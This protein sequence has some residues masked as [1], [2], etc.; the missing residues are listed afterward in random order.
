LED[1]LDIKDMMARVR[2]K[3]EELDSLEQRR[4]NLNVVQPIGAVPT[5]EMEDLE[6]RIRSQHAQ[7][8]QSQEQVFLRYVAASFWNDYS[9]F[10]TS[11]DSALNGQDPGSKFVTVLPYNYR[12]ACEGILHGYEPR[13]DAIQKRV[14]DLLTGGIDAFAPGLKPYQI[15]AYR[16]KDDPRRWTPWQPDDSK[17]QPPQFD[18]KG[19]ADS[20]KEGRVR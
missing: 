19:A 12:A 5:P 10:T 4:R 14:I 18:L 8:M 20:R 1:A 11:L 16:S 9:D 7:L 17:C 13:H 2:E 6:R 3:K 15:A